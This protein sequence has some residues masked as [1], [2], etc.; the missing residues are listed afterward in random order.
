MGKGPYREGVGKASS[1]FVGVLKASVRW[2]F[3]PKTSGNRNVVKESINRRPR[4]KMIKI[5]GG[6][7]FHGS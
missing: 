4:F 7:E 2:H 6:K 5:D 3:S 1:K